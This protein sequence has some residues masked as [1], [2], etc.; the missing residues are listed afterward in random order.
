MKIT[1]KTLSLVIVL[2]MMVSMGTAFASAEPAGNSGDID[3]SVYT[4]ET[5]GAY[6]GQHTEEE[7]EALDAY[8]ADKMGGMPSNVREYSYLM[9]V[10]LDDWATLEEAEAVIDALMGSTPDN[11]GGGQQAPTEWPAVEVYTADATIIGQSYTADEMDQS[12]AWIK[13]GATVIFDDIDISKTTDGTGGETASFY[14]LGSAMIVT[15]G[16]AYVTHS[17]IWS[18]CEG[19]AGVFAYDDGVA[20][21][22][23][24]TICTS[25]S[26]GGGTG[27]GSGNGNAG[28]IHAAGG[29]TIYAWNLNIE[30]S[31]GA[32][33]PIRSDRGGGTFV[34]D[35]GTYIAHNLNATGSPAV[36]CT[37]QTTIH[38]AILTAENNE[39]ACIE[40]K[41]AV[42]LFDCVLTGDMIPTTEDDEQWNI[43]VYQSGSGDAEDGTS[44]FE[45]VG[46]SVIANHGSMFY[47]TNTASV[48]LCSHVTFSY[49]EDGNN[50]FLK[51]TGNNNTRGWTGPNGNGASCLFTA[52][53]QTIKGDFV[54]DTISELNAYFV[55][56]SV[57]TGRVYDDEGN[58]ASETVSGEPLVHDGYCN[59]YID[60]SSL[61]I[62]DGDSELMELYNAGTIIDVDGLSVTIADRD[63]NIIEQGDGAY[64]IIVD[65]YSTEDNTD[66]AEPVPVWED[67]AVER[68]AELGEA[69]EVAFVGGKGASAEPADDQGGGPEKPSDEPESPEEKY[70]VENPG[71]Y[72]DLYTDEDR[73]A[74]DKYREEQKGEMPSD[75]REYPILMGIALDDYATWEEA[76]AIVNELAATFNNPGGGAPEEYDSVLDITDAVE[77]K[78]E[79]LVSLNGDED[80]IHVLDG[81]NAIIQDCNITS[82]GSG[83]GGDMS[84]F[85]GVGSAVFTSDGTAYVSGGS[86]ISNTAG[87]AGVFG[88]DTGV[89]YVADTFI[90]TL[91][92]QSGGVHVSG[93]GTVYAWDLDVE[94]SGENSAAIR[95]DR[96]G[97]TLIV[98][99][100]RYVTHNINEAGSPAIYCTGQIAVH[101]AWLEANHCEASCIEGKNAVR[102][103]DCNLIGDMP[104]SDQD[105][106]RWNI[107]V[108]Q[109]GSGDAEVGTAYY[110]VVGGSVTAKHGEMFYTTNTAS[111]ILVSDVDFTYAPDS[112]IFLK[113]TGNNNSRGWGGNNADGNGANCNFTADNQIMDGNIVWDSIST[114]DAWLVNGTVWTGSALD[115]EDDNGTGSV[116]DGYANLY[117]GTDSTWVVTGD[118]VV[119][120]LYCAGTIEN[121]VI[122]DQAGNVLAGEGDYTVTV[123]SYS[124]DDMSSGAEPVPVWEDYAVT[125]PDGL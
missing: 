8:R 77:L 116:G 46:G 99:G 12:A 42:R 102:L 117:I 92:N 13:D 62:V 114:L 54:W 19:G 59:V 23:D 26:G 105:D 93:G 11:Q 63:G 86:I 85:Y 90:R 20:Y 48:I 41:N 29:G 31:G 118:S 70:A 101:N 64:T 88:Y 60:N 55:N 80:V 120:N 3:P 123:E 65:L 97:G 74:F 49:A 103:F 56:G 39:A 91:G 37:G 73:V 28:G 119:S 112:D 1:T 122:I 53:S 16:T 87:G 75:T 61:W 47:T 69:D 111:V 107:I 9:G 4:S 115:V 94:T 81:G 57:W 5:P 7:I 34:V 6:A 83:T 52:D 58:I 68:P 36:Y 17:N 125:R 113:C 33:A 10:T 25:E 76:C 32:S 121:A 96:G 71:A 21:V 43:F 98:D 89:A 14:G 72:A 40:G 45:I 104:E 78:G 66:G 44:Y 110:E 82:W 22:A 27:V 95:S 50:V 30:T 124:T 108:Y 109:S 100:G 79:S 38:N 18:D 51:A 15:D 106:E 35:G 67:Y 24:T 2:C 84:S